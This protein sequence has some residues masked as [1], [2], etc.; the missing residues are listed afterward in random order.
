MTSLEDRDYRREFAEEN[1][2]T[3]LAFQIRLLRESRGWTQEELAQR[4]GQAQASIS[5]LENP[6]YGRHSLTTLKRLA[7]AFDVAMA[8]R[9]VAFSELVD[10]AL[11]LTPRRLAPPSFSEEYSQGYQVGNAVFSTAS[12]AVSEGWLAGLT[13]GTSVDPAV[14]MGIGAVLSSYPGQQQAAKHEELKESQ[15]VLAA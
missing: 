4:T 8:V 10:W 15:Y 1:I 6:N 9:F 11:S 5:R 2:S 3:G 13:F 7:A 12:V 14:S